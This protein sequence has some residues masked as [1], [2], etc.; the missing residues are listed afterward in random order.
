MIGGRRVVVSVDEVEA[1]DPHSQTVWLRPE[2]PSGL[3]NH[4]TLRSVPLL[5]WQQPSVLV[6]HGVIDRPDQPG[7]HVRVNTN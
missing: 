4:E 5:G 6:D 7:E 3:P 2:R 1:L